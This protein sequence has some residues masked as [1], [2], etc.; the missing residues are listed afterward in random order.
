MTTEIHVGN[1]PIQPPATIFLCFYT[2]T[3]QPNRYSLCK[4]GYH[5]AFELLYEEQELRVIVNGQ[6]VMRV[7]DLPVG[8][9]EN[10]LLSA[11]F[12]EGQRMTLYF[13]GL[14]VA[15]TICPF[16]IFTNKFILGDRDG[17]L[18]TT[19]FIVL[20]EA[21]SAVKQAAF[22]NDGDLLNTDL[23]F[24]KIIYNFSLSKQKQV[25]K[26]AMKIDKYKNSFVF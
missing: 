25:K 9:S 22:Y 15:E 3:T 6:T 14:S 11:V 18:A 4:N 21:V 16:P 7:R 12:A 19:N 20:A 13:D 23:V 1:P 8:D 26:E 10:H 2:R 5:R 24:G 17:Q